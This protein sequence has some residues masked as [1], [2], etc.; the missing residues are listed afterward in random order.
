[1]APQPRKGSR[2]HRGA[3]ARIIARLAARYA[4][5]LC[6]GT[7][8]A[9]DVVDQA[10]AL[11]L[12]GSVIQAQIIG[13]AVAQAIERAWTS[14]LP[15]ADDLPS[16]TPHCLLTPRQTQVLAGLAEGKS[17]DQIAAELVLAPVTVR[18]HVANIL[19]ALGVHSRLEA[20]ARARRWSLIDA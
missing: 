9:G 13:P 7:E 6:S 18:N 11:G 3:K 15:N 17:T 2:G 8:A 16:A 20:V 4:E 19:V 1:M 5:A 12:P 10:V 14:S